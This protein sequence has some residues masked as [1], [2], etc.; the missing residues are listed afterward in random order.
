MVTKKN[1]VITGA[2]GLIGQELLASLSIRPDLNVTAFVRKEPKA[3]LANVTYISGSLP[4]NIPE[5]LFSG[6]EITLIHL[7]SELRAQTPEDYQRTNVLGTRK[8]LEIAGNKISK[9]IYNSS[10]SV[11]GQGPFQNITETSPLYPETELAISRRDA[12]NVIRDYANKN[13]ISSFILRPR[14]LLGD[15]DKETLPALL[16][17]KKK[18]LL[19]GNG[20]QKYSFIAVPDYVKIISYLAVE[21]SSLG[22]NEVNIAYKTPVS[23]LDI[24]EA[25]GSHSSYKKVPAK[26]IMTLGRYLP[27]L[28]KLRTKLQLIGQDQVMD[29]NKLY[30]LC[31]FMN[32]WDGK[33]RIKEIVTSYMR[34]HETK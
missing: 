24:Y 17:L 29:V 15:R 19:I 10:M 13:N 25:E 14:F 8:L 5:A 12:E 4:D 16:K 9:I 21:D 32:E 33:A 23:L 28:K 11:Y 6:D 22:L 31:P 26:F 18:A 7:A 27:P 30:S 1:I 3:R 2:N 34:T 20:Q